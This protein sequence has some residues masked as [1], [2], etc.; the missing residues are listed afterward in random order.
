MRFGLD[1]AQQQLE[2]RE[3]LERAQLAED[4]GFDGVWMFDHFKA[5]YGDPSGPCFEAYTTMAAIAASTTRVRL[6][7]MV[8]GMTYRHPSL[9]ASEAVTVDHISDGRLELAVGAAWF[10]QEH[11]ELGWEFPDVRIRAQRLDE[12]IDIMRLLMTSDHVDYGGRHFRLRD[13]S[14]NPRPVQRPHPPI[15]VGASG[16]Q[17]MIPIAAR[18]AD[19]WHTFGDLDR[20]AHKTEA[21]NRCAREAGRDPKSIR[22]ATS[23]GISESWET[24]R[25]RMEGVAGL[26]FSYLYVGWPS[27]GESRLREF[28]TEIMPESA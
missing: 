19:V 11:D 7:A 5:M 28:A 21:L 24:I 1:V 16:E 8:T 22:R 20:L 12:G 3:I 25:S 17:L 18:Q 10:K 4:L 27:E 15:W 26:G 9:L 6:G 2:W 23:L 13:A 14:Y